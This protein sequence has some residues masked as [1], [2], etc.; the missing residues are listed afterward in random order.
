MKREAQRLNE[1]RRQLFYHF[2]IEV[3]VSFVNNS[4]AQLLLNSDA[5]FE[6]RNVPG[7]NDYKLP[8]DVCS[9]FSLMTF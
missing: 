8:F 7:Y 5:V 4:L 1:I 3:H 9:L 6:Y 2:L